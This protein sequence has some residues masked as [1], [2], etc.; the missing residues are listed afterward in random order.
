MHIRIICTPAKAG[1]RI[2]PY[3]IVF[4]Y[5]YKNMLRA[6][7]AD[8][9]T[10]PC[11]AHVMGKY[12]NLFILYIFYSLLIKRNPPVCEEPP[13]IVSQAALQNGIASL[14]PL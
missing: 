3:Y 4:L 13:R 8:P 9:H 5:F 12:C 14:F 2:L 7:Y 6:A 1:L 11:M 10:V